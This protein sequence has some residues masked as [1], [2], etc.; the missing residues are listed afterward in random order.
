MLIIKNVDVEFEHLLCIVHINSTNQEDDQDD[1]QDYCQGDVF[2]QDLMG[3]LERLGHCRTNK[4][5][6]SSGRTF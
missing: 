5:F 4:R 2:T 1:G 3:R 6:S